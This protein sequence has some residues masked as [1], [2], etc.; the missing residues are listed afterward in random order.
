MSK[1]LIFISI[2]GLIAALL[3]SLFINRF[4]R[5]KL[6]SVKAGFYYIFLFFIAGVAMLF[7]SLSDAAN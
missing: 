6:T 4:D 7:L 3:F 2:I 5:M 1:S